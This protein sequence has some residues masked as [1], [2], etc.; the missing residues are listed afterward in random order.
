MKVILHSK[1]NNEQRQKLSSTQIK[2]MAKQIVF[3]QQ[4]DT[5]LNDESSDDIDFGV[6][7]LDN[8]S[9]KSEIVSRNFLHVEW[10]GKKYSRHYVTEVY[11]VVGLVY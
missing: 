6:N 9:E 3:N 8:E 7:V 4:S 5:S 1:P 10:N 11:E 2:T